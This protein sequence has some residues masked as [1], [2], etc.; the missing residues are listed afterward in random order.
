MR[1]IEMFGAVVALVASTA[2]IPLL[3]QSGAEQTN[4]SECNS[5]NAEPGNRAPTASLN[6][7]PAANGGADRF[8]VTAS[9]SDP[10][11]DAL[12]Y[13]YTISWGSIIGEG[14]EVIWDLSDAY[15]GTYELTVFVNDSRGCYALVT[16]HVELKG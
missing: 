8:A 11:G 1:L 2:A 7:E 15:P 4:V 3:A 5:N 16:H 9:A 14:A 10:D 13:M 12:K 6:I